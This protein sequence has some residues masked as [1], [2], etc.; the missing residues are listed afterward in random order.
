MS[1]HLQWVTAAALAVGGITFISCD[2]RDTD[3]T[4]VPPAGTTDTGTPAPAAERM[5]AETGAGT[6]ATGTGATTQPAGGA[7]GTGATTRPAGGA[8]G[9]GTDTSGTGAGTPR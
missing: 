5:P 3:E 2:T 6:G 9:T 8:T 4:T 7:T 1:K